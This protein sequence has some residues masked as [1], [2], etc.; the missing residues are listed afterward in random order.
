MVCKQIE[1]P[2][3]LMVLLSIP[4]N[5]L[6]CILSALIPGWSSI[7]ESAPNAGREYLIGELVSTIPL[8]MI[9]ILMRERHFWGLLLPDR[10][11]LAQLEELFLT[12]HKPVPPE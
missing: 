11:L 1:I 2:Y 9:Q 7:K 12:N 8:T 6:L 10:V 5:K 4:L 3:L